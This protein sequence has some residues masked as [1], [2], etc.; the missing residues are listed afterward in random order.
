M[1]DAETATY[2]LGSKVIP[3]MVPN[4]I[5][6]EKRED[7]E[8]FAAQKG[9]DVIDFQVAYEDISPV[10]TTAPFRVRT[11]VTPGAGNFSLGVVYGYTEK[12]QIKRGSSSTDATDFI[13]S[14]P[15]QPKAP[16]DL[17]VQ[18]QALVLNYSP[19]DNIALFLNV[20]WFERR[21]TTQTQ[22]APNKAGL[23]TY[24]ETIGDTNGIGDIVLEMR[25]NFWRT[26]RWDK[27]AT[28]FLG[29]SLPTGEFMGREPLTAR[30]VCCAT[31]P[32]QAA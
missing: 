28:L 24:G 32:R 20:P 27:F 29:T 10:G 5:A 21:L 7:A 19:T 1:V 3:D 15:Y 4:Y 12:D 9:G 30:R 18:Q 23:T 31:G 8:A 6:F 2:V 22:T 14:N 11:A 25:Y 17:Q 26:T 13:R 16:D